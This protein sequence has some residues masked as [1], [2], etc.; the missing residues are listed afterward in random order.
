MHDDS[1]L[2]SVVKEESEASSLY[3]FFTSSHI[4]L[5]LDVVVLELLEDFLLEGQDL[6]K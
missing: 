1:F 3:F 4:D 6:G 5:L 2:K